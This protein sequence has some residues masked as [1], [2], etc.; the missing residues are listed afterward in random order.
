[1][2]LFSSVEVFEQDER[3]AKMAVEFQD[4]SQWAKSQRKTA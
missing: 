1:V 4:L 2:C 3:A